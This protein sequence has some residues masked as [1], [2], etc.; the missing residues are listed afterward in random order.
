ME[1]AVRV[2]RILTDSE[3]N[4]RIA[5]ET[6]P[7]IEGEVLRTGFAVSDTYVLTAWHCVAASFDQR[8]WFRLRQHAAE[9]PRYAYVPVRLANYS[10]SLDVA[11]LEIDRPSLPE[12]ALTEA[13]ACEMLRAASIPVAAQV[14]LHDQVRVMGFPASAPSADSDSNAAT[15]VE[16]ELSIGNATAVKLYGDA[17]AAVDPVNPRGLSG[18]PVLKQA[19]TAAGAP[20]PEAAVAVIRAVSR[21]RYPYTTSGGSLVATHM[22][23]VAAEL[24]EIAGLFPVSEP[25]RPTAGAGA[26]AEAGAAGGAERRPVVPRQLPPD[27]A[28]FTGRDDGVDYLDNL[29]VGPADPRRTAVISAIDG[30]AGVGK[31]ALAIHW[32]Y[33]VRDQFPDGDLYVNLRGYDFSTPVAAS[34]AMDYFLRALGVAPAE[35][36]RDLDERTSLYRSMLYNRAILLV[37]DNAASV[38]QVAPLLPTSGSAFALV[39]SRS[40]LPGLAATH[41]TAQLS[42]DLLSEAEAIALFEEIIGSDRVR[43]EADVAAHL[44]RQCARLPLALR[45]VA[46]NVKFRLRASLAAIAA[47]LGGRGDSPGIDSFSMPDESIALEAVFDWSYRQLAPDDGRVFRRLGLHPGSEISVESASALVMASARET[48]RSLYRLANVHMVEEVGEGRFSFHD[49]MRLYAREKCDDDDAADVRS[50]AFANLASW[51]IRTANNANRLLLQRSPIDVASQLTGTEPLAFDGFVDALAWC[52][53]ERDNLTLLTAQAHRGGLLDIAWRL[54]GVLRGFYNLRKH[55]SDWE[56]T[57][58]IALRAA[59]QLADPHAEAAVMNGIGTLLKQTRRSAQAIG[60]HQG[61]LDRRRA[62]GDNV[63]VASSLDGLGHAYRDVG[64]FDDAVRCFQESLAIRQGSGDRKG[65]G[66]SNNNLGEIALET[67]SPDTALT[68]FGFA[69]DA[70]TEVGDRWGEGRTLHGMGQAHEALGQLAQARARYAQAVAVRREITDRW[71]V[72]QS[73][74]SWA[75]TERLLGDL[76]RAREL[77]AEAL[78]ILTE[79]GDPQAASVAAKIAAL[80]SGVT[81]S[82]VTGSGQAS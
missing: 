11:V 73:L 31:T 25:G 34:D 3:R 21:G 1:G 35:I 20:G 42:L 74:D 40:R 27:I 57:H 19:P 32:A 55:W 9:I 52:E 5:D 43:R 48:R 37:L 22:A 44:V 59:Q 36:P 7:F 39:T 26:G 78:V 50:A 65:Q 72:A 76:E 47:D 29:L 51:Y 70:R 79:L 45:I 61:A 33:R 82:G 69:L 75:D 64:R 30:T 8:V 46:E 23:E 10:Q 54:P 58:D 63:G 6:S 53:L 28:H 49:L 15:V 62:L 67:G 16:L 41:G 4:A 81:E 77:W 38:D 12:V 60:F 68:F 24:P 2:G 18:G 14:A 56:T 17:F 71:G 80:E 13:A 66:W